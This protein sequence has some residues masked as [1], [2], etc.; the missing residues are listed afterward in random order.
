[1]PGRRGGAVTATA[2][3]RAP[4]N[5]R[6]AGAVRYQVRAVRLG[7]HGKVLDRKTSAKTSANARS[8]KLVLQRGVY[9]FQVRAV[10]GVGASDWSKR[11]N[12]VRAR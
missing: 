3:W 6:A 12:K 10:N 7:A 4:E 5:A 11:S 9:R 2:R 8:Q 1:V